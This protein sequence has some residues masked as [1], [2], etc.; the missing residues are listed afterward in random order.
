MAVAARTI[1]AMM[2]KPEPIFSK[3][4]KGIDA[5]RG[6]ADIPA[7]L[8]PVL[9]LVDGTKNSSGI[10]AAAKS[11]G[12]S[13]DAVRAALVELAALGLVR[14]VERSPELSAQDSVS[15]EVERR[16]L[17]TLDFTNAQQRQAA[18]AKPQGTPPA[19]AAAPAT[20][21]APATPVVST[22]AATVA[23]V[24]AAPVAVPSA[25]QEAR[26]REARAVRLKLEA[27]IRQK[28]TA[29]LQPRIEEELRNKL[30][31]KLEEELRPKLIAALRPGLEAAMKTALIK[32][33]TPKIE[34]ELKAQL[35][36][37]LVAQK[38]NAQKTPDVQLAVTPPPSMPAVQVA[39][40]DSSFE[41]ILASVSTPVFSVDKTGACTYMSPAWAQLSGYAAEEAAGK[42]LAGFFDEK[43]RRAITAMLV[44]IGDGT[45]MRFEQQ[46]ALARKGGDS[47]WVEIS[48]APLYS[49]SGEAIGACGTLRDA[50]EAR[51]LTE[52]AEADGVKLLLLVDR[53]EA[54]VL[55]EDREGNIQ[56]VNPGFCALFSVEAAAYSLEGLPVSE[57]LEQA[58]QAFIDPEAY[59]RRVAD[60]RG[61]D[62]DVTGEA[63]TLADGRVIE[64]DYLGVSAGEET[65]GRI[66]LFRETFPRGTREPHSS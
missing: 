41:R 54:G 25:D 7:A 38:E 13:E 59:L 18:K 57:I 55:L 60:L 61:A 35:A 2:T 37:T 53:L 49:S 8:R 24:S 48:A 1:P 63:F 32:T 64:Q 23:P 9:K 31:P 39:V 15:A 28:L 47:L 26:M 19:A 10:V 43:N 62:D 65:V 22:V 45:A 56:Q 42:S 40:A 3:T 50:A 14:Q 5:A 34:Q 27:D 20:P 52:Q 46:G 58:S 4:L 12:V 21:K 11:S 36:K 44:G 29:V 66:W 17:E 51:R 16:L 6:R 33:L 30:R